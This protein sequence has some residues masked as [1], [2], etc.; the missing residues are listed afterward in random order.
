MGHTYTNLLTHIIFSTKDRLPYLRNDRRD[1]VVAYLG[2]IVR[3]LKGAAINVNGVADHVHALV[4]L[5][6]C[7]VSREGS[8][9]HQS[10]FLA[11]DSRTSRA[12]SHVCMANGICGF[13]R[14]RVEC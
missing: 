9:N 7:I 5:P 10:Q 13:Q 11:L 2:G 3:E 1:D 4:R 12:S 14:K 8:R 6:G